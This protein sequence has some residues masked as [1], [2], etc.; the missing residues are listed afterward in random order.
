MFKKLL[1]GFI[2]MAVALTGMPVTS[3]AGVQIGDNLQLFGDVRIRL[4]WDTRD[5]GT[6]VGLRD[7]NRERMRIRTRFGVNYQT[8]FEP[9]SLGFRLTTGTSLWSPHQ[10]V[11]LTTTNMDNRAAGIDL[12][13]AF[14]KFKF[15]ETGTAV[16][17]KQAYPFWQ[18][19]EQMF[20]ADISPPGY[21]A[22]YTADLGDQGK[23]TFGAAYFYLINNGW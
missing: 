15:L 11:D 12:D 3:Y 9:L 2:V 1:A 10:T 14:L 17:G 5:P 20:D 23:L 8:A 18:Q 7:D 6:G 22:V 13:R 21:A 19:T 16:L 4:E